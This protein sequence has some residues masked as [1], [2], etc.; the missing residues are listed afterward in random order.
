MIRSATASV[1]AFASIVVTTL[2]VAVPTCYS[3]PGLV[4]TAASATVRS[5]PLHQGRGIYR[6]LALCAGTDCTYPARWRSLLLG[7]V[8][9]L[10]I[11]AGHSFTSPIQGNQLIGHS[12]VGAAP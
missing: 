12:V 7:S 10:A 1:I 3:C 6:C 2:A 9:M 11:I 4:T 5:H 8:A